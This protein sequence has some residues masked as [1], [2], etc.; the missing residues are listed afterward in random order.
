MTT[1]IPNTELSAKC[2]R[3]MRAETRD[4]R[5]EERFYEI[6]L[7]GLAENAANFVSHDEWLDDDTHWIWVMAHE[8]YF[9]DDFA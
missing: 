1:I 8:E 6:T 2:R 9:Y 3:Q 4:A 7:M 5:F